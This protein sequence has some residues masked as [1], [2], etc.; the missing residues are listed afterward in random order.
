MQVGT[1]VDDEMSS[2]SVGQSD[3]RRIC[4]DVKTRFG[5]NQMKN[6][7]CINLEFTIGWI[8]PEYNAF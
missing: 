7:H 2:R 3:S 6:L 4:R 5:A 1:P 8:L